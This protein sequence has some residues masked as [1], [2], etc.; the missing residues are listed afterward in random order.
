LGIGDGAEEVR[1]LEAALR[2]RLEA[3]PGLES[4]ANDGLSVP[5]LT[6]ARRAPAGLLGP[7]RDAFNASGAAW[8]VDRVVLYRSLLGRLGATHVPILSAPLGPALRVSAAGG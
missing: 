7:L 8:S 1:A 2:G 6:I 5:H 3:I 4:L